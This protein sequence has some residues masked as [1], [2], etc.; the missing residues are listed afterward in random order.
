MRLKIALISIALSIS[1]SA[2]VYRPDINQGNHIDAEKLNQLATGMTR[3]QVEFL[4]GRAAIND[5]LHA[6][7]AHYIYYLLD[8]DTQQTEQKTMILTYEDD[9]LVNIE[10]SL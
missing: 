3:S 9:V 10:G 5:P 4:L 1:A 6:N 2:C 8:G 7:K